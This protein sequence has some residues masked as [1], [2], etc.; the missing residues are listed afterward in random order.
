MSDFLPLAQNLTVALKALQMYTATHP[1]SQ[2]AAAAAHA[3]LDRWLAEQE[4]LQF[5][6]SGTK[7]FVD[8]HVQEAKNP[9]I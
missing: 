8:G 5:V 6:I 7:A 3:K 9:H 4:R 1:R 2:E